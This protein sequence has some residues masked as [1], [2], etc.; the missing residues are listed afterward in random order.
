[1]AG[2]D[3]AM[4]AGTPPQKLNNLYQTM[5]AAGGDKKTR[6]MDA[7]RRILRMKMAMGLFDRSPLADA[8]V[9]ALAGSQLHRDVARACVRESMVLLKNNNN[10]LPLAK[11]ARVHLV[12]PHADNMG[13]QC[14]GW[15]LGWAEQ[16]LTNDMFQGATTI[17]QGFEK[18][19]PGKITYTKDANTMPA[20]AA[21]VVVFFGE[22]VHA[23]WF[24]DSQDLGPTDWN[25]IPGDANPVQLIS[26]ARK[27]GK[28]VI[29]VMIS[30]R[31]MIVSSY[32]DSLDA[33]VCAWLPG[34]EGGGI[35]E[36]LYG[37]YDFKG[38]LP[39]SWPSAFIQEP[40]NVSTTEYG[41]DKGDLKGATGTWQWQ[42]GYGLSYKS[43]TLKA[44]F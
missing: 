20:D 9:T 16:N 3:M 7:A 12:G 29:G 40:L 26:G 25:V 2:L 43:G 14:G 24:G 32:I 27:A 42:Y 34:T 44:S 33:F 28:P 17:K 38:T 36:V 5:Y 15:T 30:S 35:A 4:Q 22:K 23:E 13:Y 39:H 11:T 6:V 37:D 21:A 31:P 8:S 1:M 10:V 19:A 18:L 41:G